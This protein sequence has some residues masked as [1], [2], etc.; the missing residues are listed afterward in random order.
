MSRHRV[1]TRLALV[2][3]AATFLSI[4]CSQEPDATQRRTPARTNARRSRATEGAVT[5][6]VDLASLLSEVPEYG[7]SGR[8]LFAFGSRPVVT[9]PPRSETP[10]PPPPR[11]VTRPPTAPV[12]ST[13]R[14]NLKFA[15][16]VE[17]KTVQGEMKKYAVLLDGTEIL[18]GAEGDLVANRYKIVQIGLESVTLGVAGSNDTQRIPLESN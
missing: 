8:N 3:L 7:G 12:T 6:S 18:T 1:T 15:G 13:P 10:A 17:T 5:E 4:G 14:I 11:P 16:Y 2:G 9:P